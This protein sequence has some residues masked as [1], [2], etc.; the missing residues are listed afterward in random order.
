MNSVVSEGS[1]IKQRSLLFSHGDDSGPGPSPLPATRSSQEQLRAGT[2]VTPH[3]GGRQVTKELDGR[4]ASHRKWQRGQGEERRAE[5]GQRP[6]FPEMPEERPTEGE[7]C[8]GADR[9]RR[10][11]LR[12]DP[13]V[14]GREARPPSEENKGEGQGARAALC[15]SPEARARGPWGEVWGPGL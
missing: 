14:T 4:P 13:A 9:G 10:E 7:S 5:A 3:R 11:G 15:S 6:P 12:G 2:S 1:G 8:R